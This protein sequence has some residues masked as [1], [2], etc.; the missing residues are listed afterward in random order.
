MRIAKINIR[1]VVRPTGPNSKWLIEG[2]R[3]EAGKRIRKFFPN[4]DAAAEWLR[5]RR[6]ELKNQGRSAMGMTDS[7]RIDA[8]RALAILEPYGVNLTKAA[9]DFVE[10]AKLL[11]RTVSFAVLADELMA[12]KK[13]DGASARYVKDIKHK[14]AAFTA[15]FGERPAATIEKREIDDWLRARKQSPLTRNN[16]R[17][18]LGVAF[19]FAVSRGY[20]R[21]NPVVGT[22]EAKVVSSS[23]GTLRPV[24]FLAL[25]TYAPDELVPALAIGG[26]AGLREAEIGRLDWADI[27][28]A[29]GHIRI[30][31]ATAKT[32]SRRIVPVLPALAA[33]LAPLAKKTGPV[34]VKKYHQKLRAARLDAIAAL[35]KQQVGT[36]NLTEWPHNA[37]RHSF[38][39]YRLSS[40]GNAAQ[41]A[42]EAGHG[43]AMLHRHYKALVTPAEGEAWFALRPEKQDGAVVAFTAGAA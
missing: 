26:F 9:T 10:R 37:L 30:D 29:E 21:E 1:Q 16:Y 19:S 12:A 39:S 40:V 3:D 15:D 22:A 14:L 11:S 23:P 42:L 20:A 41:V 28:L 4:R 24:E 31:A 7:Q 13:A 34:H 36:P 32:A 5:L 6:P 8:V 18:N 17:R 27:N 25:L 35:A 33:W 43:Q 38:V 2:L